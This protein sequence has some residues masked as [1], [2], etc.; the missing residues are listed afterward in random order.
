MY[1]PGVGPGSHTTNNFQ[2]LIISFKKMNSSKSSNAVRPRR[3]RRAQNAGAQPVSVRRRARKRNGGVS[4]AAVRPLPGP[5]ILGRQQS[6]A[7]AYST[8]QY[9]KP[10]Q[11]IRA[12]ADSTRI[13]HREL[14]SSVTG[15]VAF[16]VAQTLA[17]NPGLSATFPWLS[18]QAQGWER[19]RFNKLKFCYYTRT[20]SNVPGSIQLAPDYDAA[21]VA[22]ISEA[23]ASTYADC[24]EDAPWKDIV[25]ELKPRNMNMARSEHFVR[26]EPLGANL[27]IKT[28]DV[29][30]LFVNTVDGTAV[31]WGKLW[32]EYDVTFM[33]PQFNPQGA[34]PFGG[35][36]TGAGGGLTAAK[37]FGATPTVLGKG[38][39][40]ATGTNN[41]ITFSRAGD[42]LLLAQL[43]GT[44][45]TGTN[46]AA[47][48]T[49]VVSNVGAGFL[50]NGAGT[51]AVSMT[52][53]VG[54][55]AGDTLTLTATATTV[56]ASIMDIAMAPSATLV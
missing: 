39:S 20:G 34:P 2:P 44:V 41:V 6:V 46:V 29:A 22:P 33:A 10:P 19:Y 12:S 7:A 21:D 55:V 48:G 49:G 18:V 3:A 8:G 17:I 45:I 15:S 43:T 31:A 11:I 53:I 56:T 54:A 38:F 4:S 32:V 36:I 25:C 9:Q 37:P 51:I 50:V 13:V 5:Q 26:V 16:T 23:V 24:A 28:Y 1:S 30:N 27:D 47:T 40:V 14:V 35:S 42:F 52:K